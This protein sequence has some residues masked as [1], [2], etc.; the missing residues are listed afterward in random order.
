MEYFQDLIEYNTLPRFHRY[1][2]RTS[3]APLAKVALIWCRNK[4][5]AFI[6]LSYLP[7]FVRDL[8]YDQMVRRF[9]RQAIV[10]YVKCVYPPLPTYIKMM[11]R[12]TL[13]KLFL[14]A[15]G[16]CLLSHS[17]DSELANLTRLLRQQEAR[18]KPGFVILTRIF[19]HTWSILAEGYLDE[20]G[21]QE[22]FYV[23]FRGN[24]A[25]MLD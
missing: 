25:D 11:T 21:N 12:N 7:D 3:D 4:D 16:R 8:N 20:R 2:L 10:V 24:I 1:L 13:H 23:N 15:Y 19:G 17:D 5:V 9:K 6:V 14:L 18:P 22:E